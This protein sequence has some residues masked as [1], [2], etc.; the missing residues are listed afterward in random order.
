[1][2]KN[3]YYNYYEILFSLRKEYLKNQEIINR[4]L[5]YI[6][7]TSKPLDEYESNLVFKTNARTNADYLLLIVKKRQHYIKLLLD[8]L[9]SHLVSS[10]SDLKSGNFSYIFRLSKE[11]VS[12]LDDT[13]DG[14]YLKAKVEITN[15]GE[16]IELYRQLMENVVCKQGRIYLFSE[17]CS[18]QVSNNGIHLFHVEGD[19]KKSVRL[20]YSG[21][22]DCISI[23]NGS[24]LESLM[25]LE[26][27]RGMIP[28][29]LGSIIESN[30]D[31]Y[32]YTIEGNPDNGE[33]FYAIE[34]DGSKL[35]L[36]PS[37]PLPI[38][39]FR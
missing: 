3:G 23:N 15:Q 9:Y 38:P 5:S 11:Y 18:V 29:Y 39:T 20:D 25:K 37:R 31:N 8:S 21:L 13:Q 4:L 16:F 19:Y 14:R 10:D 2:A 17:K 33:A 27:D 28:D 6:R 26:I 24:Y 35:V 7:I 1:M 22:K 12:L 36:K 32:S 30:M 34:D